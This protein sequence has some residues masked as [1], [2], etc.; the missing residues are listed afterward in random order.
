[1]LKKT[2]LAAVA[3]F[4][5]TAA[6]AATDVA[7]WRAQVDQLMDAGEFTQ[8]STLMKKLPKKVRTQEAVTIDSLNQIMDRIRRD[9][10]LSPE[11]G[12]A[13]IRKKRPDAT[14]EQIANWKR[15]KAIEYMNIDGKEV[16]FRKAVRNLWLLGEEFA[17]DNKAEL[18]EE[19]ES[20]RKY[21]VRAMGTQPDANGIRDW[22]HVN[23]T[24]TLD[25][26]PDAIP[27]GETL[28]VWMPIPYENLRQKN[29]KLE[30]SNRPVTYSEGSKHHTIY[31]EAVA[32]K[33]QPTHFEYT[34]SYDVGER[35]I[36][37]Q[38]LMAMVQP[39]KMTDEYVKYTSSEYPHI[40]ITDS[41][42]SLAEYIVGGAEVHP[43][44]AANHIFHWI[45]IN[46]PW[47]GAREY[48][49][50]KNIPEYVLENKHGDCGQV[51][52]LY[53]TLCRA[54][55][56][57][58]RWE[59]GY[60]LHPGAVNFH[61]WGETYFEGVG[62]VPTDASFGR[63]TSPSE[64]MHDYYATGID[65][66]RMASNEAV[67][68]QLSPAKKYIRSE[69][70]DFQMGEVEWKGGNLYYDKWSSNFKLNSMEPI[71]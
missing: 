16:W 26:K 67:G 12:I 60:M 46:F 33:G 6:Q 54:V 31:M 53:I 24:F 35:H 9:F 65:I 30:S 64:Q 61:D 49:T 28:R 18:A 11:E 52:L 68:D 40:V 2:I 41:I 20:M 48:S 45:A 4:G 62:W 21:A 3:C 69:T 8:A 27:A 7:T 58:A 43:V 19:S 38:D 39:Y 5:F 17:A 22:H 59:S 66:Y 25:V 56:I 71:K 57:P 15:L 34:F 47:A 51:G 70:V 13:A 44:M 1:M 50:I 32:E 23:V 55:G 37:Q 10:T 14:D 63:S 29:I 42:R 36:A